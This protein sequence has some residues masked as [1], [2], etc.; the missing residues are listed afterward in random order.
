MSIQKK[1]LISA[2]KTAKKANV[3]SAGTHDVDSKGVASM[4]LQHPRAVVSTKNVAPKAPIVSAK[5]V[6]AKSPVHSFKGVS[7]KSLKM[8][9]NKSASQS[10][11]SIQ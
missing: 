7:T 11:K 1:S 8:T 5:N 6:A 9:S 2:L 3:A 10:L 4:R